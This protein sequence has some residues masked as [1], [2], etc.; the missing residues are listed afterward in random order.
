MRVTPFLCRRS[1]KSTRVENGRSLGGTC[2]CGLSLECRLFRSSNSVLD[3]ANC[4]GCLRDP[5]RHVRTLGKNTA[6]RS[7]Q[8]TSGNFTTNLRIRFH[9]EVI[10]SLG[11]KTGTDCV[12]A[13]IGLPRKKTCAG[14][15]HP[16]R[17][18][19]P[20]LVGTSVA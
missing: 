18:T 7:F 5:V 12:C 9:G 17:N 4:F 13:G 19:S 3:I 6:L 14:G 1:C 8:G 11:I 16:L 15:R 10:G 20:I 2:G